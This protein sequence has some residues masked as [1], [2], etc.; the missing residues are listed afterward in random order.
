LSAYTQL[1]TIIAACAFGACDE[2]L[3]Q[4]FFQQYI[5][6]SEHLMADGVKEF[7]SPFKSALQQT[8]GEFQGVKD[9]IGSFPQTV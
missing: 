6:D 2:G 5:S 1:A 8:S 3:I 7:L 4:G 9:D